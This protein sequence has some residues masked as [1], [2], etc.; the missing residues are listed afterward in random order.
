MRSF[1][2][3][4]PEVKS[5]RAMERPVLLHFV[6]IKTAFMIKQQSWP[7]S[8]RFQPCIKSLWDQFE[9]RFFSVLF[10]PQRSE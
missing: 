10:R 1:D 3:C 2:S 4:L 5:A 7:A 9:A 8:I 6:F